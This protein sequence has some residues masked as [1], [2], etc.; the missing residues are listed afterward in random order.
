MINF[1]EIQQIICEG[2]HIEPQILRSKTRKREVV[3]TRQ[4]IMYFLKQ[5]TKESLSHIGSHFNR[6]HATVIHACKQI[7][8]LSYSDW[9]IKAKVKFYEHMITKLNNFEN[10]IIIDKFSEIQEILRLKIDNKHI[11]NHELI[12]IYNKLI[13]K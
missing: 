6:D 12:V 13:S 4:L 7:N 1:P 9:D 3:F 8:D 11:I 10:N 5:K 2:E